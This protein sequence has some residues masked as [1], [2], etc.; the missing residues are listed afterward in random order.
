MINDYIVSLTMRV[1]LPCTFVYWHS[2]VAARARVNAEKVR[3]SLSF[4]SAEEAELA[5]AATESGG[6]SGGESTGRPGLG[7]ML[8]RPER[9]DSTHS[10]IW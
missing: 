10:S 8:S 5:T 4:M 2:A 6:L 3:N 7:Q 1:V 9:L